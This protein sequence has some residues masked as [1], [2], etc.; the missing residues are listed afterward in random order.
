MLKIKNMI[1]VLFI[2]T[3]VSVSCQNNER[4]AEDN[5][6]M[7]ATELKEAI[8]NDTNLVILDVR[9]P[10]ELTGEHGQ[11]EGLINIPVQVLGER[12]S[13][14]DK[15][16]EKNIAV[17]CRSGNRSVFAT[18]IMQGKGFNAKNV[19]GGMKAYNKL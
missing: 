19:L 5:F 14:L 13:E 9:T 4:P 15:Y 3:T 17:I 10:A 16:K 6:N 7:T 18:K 2:I 8:K 11:I 1:I 12:V